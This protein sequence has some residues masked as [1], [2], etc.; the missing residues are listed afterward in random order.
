M[1]KLLFNKIIILSLL[2]IL[3]TSC[4]VKDVYDI[5]TETV[6]VNKDDDAEKELLKDFTDDLD[7]AIG[8]ANSL[9][10]LKNKDIDVS[11]MYPWI[12]SNIIGILTDERREELKD[13]YYLNVNFNWLKDAKL[14]SGY[15]SEMPFYDIKETVDEN[16][17]ALLK[18]E[19]LSGKDYNLI[20]DFYDLWLDFEKRNE[21]GLLPYKNFFESLARVNNIDE[22]SIFLSSI[23]NFLY[24]NNLTNI[25]LSSNSEDSNLY[26]VQIFST[27]L[28][29]EDSAEYKELTEYGKRKKKSI[30][31]KTRYMLKQFMYD[32]DAIDNIINN[33]F[34]FET[35]I[36]EFEKSVLYWSNEEALKE[37]INPITMEEIKNKNLK[38]PLFEILENS[39]YGK[40]D[41]INILEPMWLD[42]IDSIY[43]EENLEEMKDYILVHTLLDVMPIIDEK[44][45]RE[46]Q[47]INNELNGIYTNREDV[48]LA[49]DSAR[50][51]FPYCFDRLYVE[52]YLDEEVRI[53]ITNMC[54]DVIETYKKMLD[55]ND[56]LSKETIKLAKEKL[57]K[58]TINAV[59]P[60]K[61]E[62]DSNFNFKSK[63]DGGSY[64]EAIMDIVR[65]YYERDLKK[66]N[67]TRDKEIWDI[68][69][70]TTNAFYKPSDNSIN[71]VA[72]FLGDST[73][74]KD[75]SIEEKYGA[76]GTVIGHEISHA[77]DTFGAQFDANGNVK[78]WWTDEDYNIFLDKADKLEKYYDNV[79]AFDN[80]IKY[81]GSLVKT[82]AIADMAS[83]KCLLKMA[84]EHKYF[85][86]DKFFR[87]YAT[88][89]AKVATLES[90][91]SNV[92]TDSHPLHYL[93][94]NV[95]IQQFDE[96]ISIYDI[97]EDNKM[98]LEPSDRI[99]I[100]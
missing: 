61:W 70:L 79:V 2:S 51:M 35:K 87:T 29:L 76:I 86:Y 42:N 50:A 77:F 46:M 85:N 98:Y 78:N 91:E 75:M 1:K 88:L 44:S 9:S 60:D 56:W 20:K 97:K 89:W 21:I 54:K 28:S 58:I 82:E 83:V 41:L 93:R 45:F 38:Y 5:L 26:E 17:M 34:S 57:D 80:D 37:S 99:N 96:F 81:S 95:T 72:G 22:L 63:N 43:N 66:I 13:D 62:D 30:E 59:Y 16:A 65:E 12:N 18:D 33:M 74:R 100:W 11:N 40:S 15:S 68:D 64:I 48:K 73:Y 25:Y 39:G 3:L 23:D 69:I 84:E 8:I 53:E 52:K 27:L 47:N 67:T 94:C 6:E 24:G 14:R 19:N 92:L 36:A 7:K 4:D 32:D 55:E 71:I 49:Y 31:D 90:L 10:Y